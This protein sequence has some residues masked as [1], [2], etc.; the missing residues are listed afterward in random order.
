MVIKMFYPIRKKKLIFNEMTIGHEEATFIIAEIGINHNGDMDIA[1]KLIDEAIKCKADAVKFQSVKLNLLFTS[2]TPETPEEER[3]AKEDLLTICKPL[4]LTDEEHYEIK[5][6]CDKKGILFFSTAG[7][8]ESFELLQKLDV[9]LVKISSNDINNFP[10]LKVIAK[11]KIPTIIST[12]MANLSEIDETIRMFESYDHTDLAILHCISNY[13]PKI[14]D[15]NLNNILTLNNCFEYPIG[16][17]DHTTSIHFSVAA[18]AMGACIIE[19]HFTLDH[20][21]EGFDHK[22]SLDPSQFK[23]MVQIIRELEKAK[24][25][26][27]KGPVAAEMSSIEVMRRSIVAKIDIPEDTIITEDMLVLKRPGTGLSPKYLDFIIGRKSQKFIYKD[28][29]IDLSHLN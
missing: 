29:L 11:S 16:F 9:P 2:P 17:S 26:F 24:G 7:D 22:A 25:S 18:V 4:L 21:M 8:I 12:G 14:E 5:E 6:Y 19:R 28:T 3:K 13:P 1:K 20:D 15:L 27:K 10:L 23:E